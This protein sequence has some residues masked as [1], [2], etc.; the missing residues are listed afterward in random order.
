MQSTAPLHGA[1]HVT[2]KW[3]QTSDQKKKSRL[4]NRR[5]QLHSA[6]NRFQNDM[7]RLKKNFDYADSEPNKG[8]H[9]KKQK[10]SHSSMQ[11][12]SG[13]SIPPG[14]QSNS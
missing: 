3:L 2:G 11:V 5:L 14:P 13:R 12:K 4:A 7:G 8:N 6:K 10:Q 1:I 9:F